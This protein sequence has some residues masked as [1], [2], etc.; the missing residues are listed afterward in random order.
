MKLSDMTLAIALAGLVA[1]CDAAANAAQSASR[2][3][4]RT[5]VR[6][7]DSALALAVK[8]NL[9]RDPVV[10]PGSLEVGVHDG[11]VS[12]YGK[13]PTVEAR[14]KAESAALMLEMSRSR[15]L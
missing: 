3:A 7:E 11:V 9:A 5:A 10:V 15:P 6:V 14:A 8:T 2:F 4:E 13:Q 1:G 12:L